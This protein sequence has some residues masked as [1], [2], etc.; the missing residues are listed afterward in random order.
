MEQRRKAPL[1]PIASRA[2]FCHLCNEGFSPVQASVVCSAEKEDL[3][4]VLIETRIQ[5]SR[6]H[7]IMVAHAFTIL[8]K[9]TSHLYGI[10]LGS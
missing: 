2:S 4:K 3:Q 7:G 1:S 8:A 5:S 9:N 6:P 10:A